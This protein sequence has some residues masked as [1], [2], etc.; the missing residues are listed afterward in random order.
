[1]WNLQDGHKCYI[2]FLYMKQ[3]LHF[4]NIITIH[5]L[6]NS[7]ICLTCIHYI[8]FYIS[9]TFSWWINIRLIE[10]LY[11]YYFLLKT[12]YIC[13]T[14]IVSIHIHFL[15]SEI[16]VCVLNIT[17]TINIILKNILKYS[18]L[19]KINFKH[20]D[21]NFNTISMIWP[22]TPSTTFYRL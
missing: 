8:I 21:L 13:V 22:S 18:Q 7:L 19:I 12:I 9:I 1:M 6:R 5:I 20:L 16:K 15:I 11:F 10:K 17:Q 14:Q 3:E 2:K 4:G